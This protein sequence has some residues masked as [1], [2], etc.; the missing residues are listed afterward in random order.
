MSY[1]NYLGYTCLLLSV[2]YNYFF[3]FVKNVLLSIAAASWVKNKQSRKLQISDKHKLK[4][5]ILPLIF[6]KWRFQSSILHFGRTFSVK[7][8]IIRQFSDSLKFRR[9]DAPPCPVTTTLLKVK[10]HM[11]TYL[12][13][14]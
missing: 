12:K 8:K 3:L 13:D 6:A 11:Q 14:G 9:A 5:S 4:I 2:F 7:K 1:R 10:V